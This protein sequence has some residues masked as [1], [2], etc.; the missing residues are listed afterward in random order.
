MKTRTIPYEHIIIL[1]KNS[2]I[3]HVY[4]VELTRCDVLSR[5]S[6][7]ECHA[8]IYPYSRKMTSDHITFCPFEE[9][10]RDIQSNQRSAYQT[11][12]SQFNKIFGLF[13]GLIMVLLFH[14][15]HPASLLSIESLLSLLGAYIIGKE[16]WNDIENFLITKTGAWK[17]KYQAG[18]YSYKLIRNSTLAVYSR[19][20]KKNR[21]GKV[22]LL[23]EKIDFI[24]QS[25]SQTLRL[26]FKKQD[27]HSIPGIGNTAHLFSIHIDPARADEL[28]KDGYLFGVKVSFNRKFLGITIRRDFFQSYDNNKKGCL[29]MQGTWCP[30]SVF[31]RRSCSFG[32][33]K[34][35]FSSGIIHNASLLHTYNDPA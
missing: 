20:A 32:R 11:L 28:E 29:T 33:I 27:Y 22:K 23:P 18:Y 8:V 14:F 1:K 3:D 2:Q 35:Y 31:F 25:N 21:Y 30:D 34:V 12:T 13:L 17:I 5:Y 24:Q 10:V 7:I 19:Y 16:L 15:F 26:F 9:Y 6:S 4:D